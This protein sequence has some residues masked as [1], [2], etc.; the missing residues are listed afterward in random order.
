MKLW[1]EWEEWQEMELMKEMEFIN[2]PYD[3]IAKIIFN[4]LS[5]KERVKWMI[6]NQNLG[7][8]NFADIEE[9]ITKLCEVLGLK[10]EKRY[11][12]TPG[13]ENE[14]SSRMIIYNL[15][16]QRISEDKDVYKAMKKEVEGKE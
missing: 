10:P 6:E 4:H 2:K 3:D 9:K 14:E 8:I 12:I 11:G 7:K 13:F 5:K 1:E 15:L 16:I